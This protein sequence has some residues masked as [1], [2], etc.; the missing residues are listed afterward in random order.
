V[1]A[2]SHCTAP[3]RD[4]SEDVESRR[5]SCEAIVVEFLEDVILRWFF[6]TDMD[7]VCS[8]GVLNVD[9]VCIA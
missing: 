4:R 8:G 5:L 2:A 1:L 6:L 7:L 9:R 3:L